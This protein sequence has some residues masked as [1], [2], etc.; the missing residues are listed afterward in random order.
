[1][2]LAVTAGDWI[3]DGRM[4]AAKYGVV[5]EIDPDIIGRPARTEV[6]FIDRNMDRN[7]A[8]EEVTSAV[9]SAQAPAPCSRNSRLGFLCAFHAKLHF[10]AQLG[11]DR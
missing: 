10:L 9:Q 3:V 2:L 7:F 11:S 4:L 1:M 5:S 8:P 6:C